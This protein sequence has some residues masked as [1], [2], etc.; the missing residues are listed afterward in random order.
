VYNANDIFNFNDTL[1][2]NKIIISRKIAN[3]LNLKKGDACFLFFVDKSAKARKLIVADMYHTGM[4]EFDK[5]YVL[6][7]LKLIQKLNNWQPNQVGG[8]EVFVKNP[9]NISSV[10]TNINDNILPLNFVSQTI[11]QLFP[12]LF[13]WLNL[14]NTTELI[15]ILLMLVVALI[16][17]ISGLLILILEQTQMIGILK[18][19]GMK[20]RG[21]RNIFIYQAANILLKGML[22]GNL[23][24]IGICAIQYYFKI[25]KLP[26][27]TYYISEV[28]I[29]FNW[30]IIF[31]INLGFALVSIITLL[32][33][34]VVINYIK[35]VK[36]IRFE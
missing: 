13:D 19:L 33:P 11:Y 25:I 12:T 8:Y 32:L 24:G 17:V 22:W 15:I 27:E 29:H 28:A 30:A 23:I 35:P 31:A 4:E 34:A 7:D 36:A 14:Q 10:C 16:N 3:R 20:A 9:K 21:I 26:E 1:A 2:S 18:T 5:V 6:A